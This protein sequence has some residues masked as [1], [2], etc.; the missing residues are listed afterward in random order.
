MKF[1]GS[2]KK[3]K[4]T[5]N[6]GPKDQQKSIPAIFSFYLE[7]TNMSEYV[8]FCDSLKKIPSN[9]YYK[10]SVIHNWPS[11]ACN[12]KSPQLYTSAIVNLVAE[13]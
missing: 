12:L 5:K 8:I 13:I 6:S 4:P 7:N 11:Y 10:A 9:V 3:G 1:Y 2:S